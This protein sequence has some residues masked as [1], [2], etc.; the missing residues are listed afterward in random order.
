VSV[1]DWYL[2]QLDEYGLTVVL[3]VQALAIVAVLC[4]AGVALHLIEGYRHRHAEAK[5]AAGLEASDIE[6]GLAAAEA[7]AND[8][9]TRAVWQHMPA[10]KGGTP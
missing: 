2:A 5:A 9:Q 7:Y 10:P 3:A 4:V 8:P 1:I 6:R